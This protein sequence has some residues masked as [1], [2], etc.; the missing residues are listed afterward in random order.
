LQQEL[1]ALP[2]GLCALSGLEELDLEYCR[3]LTALPEG[4]G[5]LAELKS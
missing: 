5:Q 1:T 3:D 2:A 4:V